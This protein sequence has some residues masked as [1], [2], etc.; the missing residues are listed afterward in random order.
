VSITLPFDSDAAIA[1]KWKSPD[2]ALA[3]R[4]RRKRQIESLGSRRV[5][6]HETIADPE[7]VSSFERWRQKRLSE[8]FG[9]R[10]SPPQDPR[11]RL[12]ILDD[13]TVSTL[14]DRYGASAERCAQAA[15]LD[16]LGLR[17]KAKRL[18]L[19]GRLGHRI[20]H[21]RSS[22]ACERLFYGP[23]FCRE[24]YCTFCGPQQFREQFAK[25]LNALT[26]IVEKLLCEGSRN[27]REMVIAKLDFTIPNKKRM[28]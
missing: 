25:L 17:S 9:S 18:V 27:G 26:P 16:S 10:Q 23:Y 20:D 13:D 22:L 8:Y 6:S 1:Q 3:Y 24:K 7:E 14:A 11:G 12:P 5:V 28:P 2:F 4:N 15:A 21:Q 19:C